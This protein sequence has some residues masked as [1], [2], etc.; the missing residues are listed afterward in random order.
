MVNKILLVKN[1]MKGV[2]S[3]FGLWLEEDEPREGGYFGNF[4]PYPNVSF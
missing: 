3:I 2:D 1:D 4:L